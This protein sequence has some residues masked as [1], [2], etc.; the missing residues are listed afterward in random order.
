[1]KTT[2]R[3]P[4]L[5][6]DMVTGRIASWRVS[7]GDPVT[8]GMVLADIETDKTILELESPADGVVVELLEAAGAEVAVGSD[9]ASL[10][11]A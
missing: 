10:E 2:V 4:N 5:G 11:T 6:Y 9:I 3:M 1:M 7:P 8:R